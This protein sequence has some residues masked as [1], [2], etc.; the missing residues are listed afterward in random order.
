LR[1]RFDFFHSVVANEDY[2]AVQRVQ[3][4]LTTTANPT[5]VFGRQEVAL[6]HFHNACNRYAG[7]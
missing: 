5:L 6:H 4:T 7:I 3:A 1:A 2:A